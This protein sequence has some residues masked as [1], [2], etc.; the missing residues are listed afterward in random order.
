LPPENEGLLC[1]L[2][3]GVTKQNKT[4]QNKTKQTN[5]KPKTKKTNKK[6]DSHSIFS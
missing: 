4:K 2:C 5:K 1:S 3:C 6:P